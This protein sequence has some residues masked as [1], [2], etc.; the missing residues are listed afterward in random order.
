MEKFNRYLDSFVAEI[1]LKNP[2]SVA[3]VDHYLQIWL[4]QIYQKKPHAALEGKTPEQ[5]FLSDSRPLRF[6]AS[7]QLSIA[8]Q[9]SEIRLVNKSGCLSFRGREYEAGQD[10]IGF[11]VEVLSDPACPDEIEI[12]HAGFESRRIYPLVIGS[13]SAPRRRQIEQ[14]NPQAAVTSR[15]LD[16]AAKKFEQKITVKRPAVSYKNHIAANEGT[17]NGHV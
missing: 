8:F 3:E 6:A 4:D 1:K 16:A 14:M 11:K 9:L 12:H 13:R 10:F 5:T 2:K 17:V 7:E 15:E